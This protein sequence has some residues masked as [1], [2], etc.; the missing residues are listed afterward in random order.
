MNRKLRVLWME[1]RDSGVS[2]DSV[3]PMPDDW[4]ATRTLRLASPT[5]GQA[6]LE[7]VGEEEWDDLETQ[8]LT[9]T[10]A[11][12]SPSSPSARSPPARSP[13]RDPP[14]PPRRPL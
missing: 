2:S 5:A 11:P 12:P 13:P 6:L 1:A 8:G 14:R 3:V 10:T 7:Y 4:L 9:G